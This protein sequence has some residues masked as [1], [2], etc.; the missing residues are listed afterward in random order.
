MGW[1]RLEVVINIIIYDPT[2]PP[3][4][5]GHPP[6]IIMYCD[7]TP[8]GGYMVKSLR[9]HIMRGDLLYWNSLKKS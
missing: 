4:L 9:L 2:H 3:N 5:W 6:Y 1:L 8:H 7:H